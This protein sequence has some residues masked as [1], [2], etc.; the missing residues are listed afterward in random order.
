M[1]KASTAQPCCICNAPRTLYVVDTKYFCST[2]RTEAY[3]AAKKSAVKTHG[4]TFDETPK[5]DHRKLRWD[6]PTY[7]HIS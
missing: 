7:S 6:S 4:Y 2:H 3:E 5:R 1:N